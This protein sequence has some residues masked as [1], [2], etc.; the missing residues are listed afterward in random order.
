MLLEKL[1]KELK[2]LDD[3]NLKSLGIL[4]DVVSV[5]TRKGKVHE[6]DISGVKEKVAIKKVMDKFNKKQKK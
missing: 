2:A 1:T 5:L 3:S 6:I 4:G